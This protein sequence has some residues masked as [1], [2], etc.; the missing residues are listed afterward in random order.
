[1]EIGVDPRTADGRGV[2]LLRTLHGIGQPA[3]RQARPYDRIPVRRWI[4]VA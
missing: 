2:V 4:A 1:M 3:R